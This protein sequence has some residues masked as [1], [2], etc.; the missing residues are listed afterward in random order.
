MFTE[1]LLETTEYCHMNELHSRLK[2]LRLPSDFVRTIDGITTVS[3][4]TLQVHIVLAVSTDGN[5]RWHLLD[6]APLAQHTLASRLF[7]DVTEWRTDIV[8]WMQ[9]GGTGLR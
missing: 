8:Y 7:K 9:I 5:L 1:T 6:M 4:E 3:G 2:S